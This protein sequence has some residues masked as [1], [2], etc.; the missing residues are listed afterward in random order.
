MEFI[1]AED[2]MFNDAIDLPHWTFTMDMV[3]PE[4]SI[5]TPDP[6]LES[7]EN[8]RQPI[9]ITF[10][11][12]VSGV[13]ISSI[14]LRLNDVSIPNDWLF[15]TYDETEQSGVIQYI[16]ESRDTF[17]IEG[18]T[19][20]IE[21]SSFD[22]IDY[23]DDNLGIFEH[24]FFVIPTTRCERYPNPLTPDA[25]GYNDV[26]LFEYPFHLTARAELVIYD[27]RKQEVSRRKFG[28]SW[29]KEDYSKR[30]WDGRDNH[31]NY[32]GQGLYLYAIIRDK[33]VIC[34]GTI[35]VVR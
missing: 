13:D 10:W 18:D 29:D 9:S 7:T 21:L 17:F 8:H 34:E 1:F 14:V 26:S 6:G 22:Q 15:I 3:P 30:F 5:E 4:Y 20:Y 32:V 16:P 33:E 2:N 28:L 31:G 19:I 35:A 25:D 11:D 12:D 23:C 24:Q 27:T